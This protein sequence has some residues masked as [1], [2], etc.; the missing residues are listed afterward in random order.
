MDA[1]TIFGEDVPCGTYLLHMQVEW[2]LWVRYGRFQQGQPVFTPAGVYLYV[3]S[4][5]GQKG[6]SS[7]ARRLLRH[8]TRVNGP[9]QAIRA[10]MVSQ[11][12]AVNLGHN[13]Q[14]P[15]VKTLHWH[16]DYLLEE[17]AVSLTHIT[18]IRSPQQ[19]EE[20]MARFLE[21]TAVC[22]MIAKGLGAGDTAV[23]SHLFHLEKGTDLRP[24]LALFIE[25]LCTAI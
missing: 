4:A 20:K 9:P 15:A 2:D 25:A 23:D 6:A 17:T 11:F 21:E 18:L 5:L 10:E 22:H 12:T 19:L 16:V 1:V 24:E 14:P 8:A 3:G 7:L 13:L